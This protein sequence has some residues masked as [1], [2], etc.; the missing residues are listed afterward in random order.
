L[1]YT[2]NS[3]VAISR[4]PAEL[5][6]DV[7]LYVVDSGLW[8]D[9]TCF[10]AGTFNFLQVCRRWSEVAVAFPRL[11][12]WWVA[13]AGKAW[14][15]FNARSKDAPLFLTWKPRLP[16]SARDAFMDTGTPR[17]IY[18]L[19][20]SSSHAQLEYVLGALDSG[21]VSVT[22]SIRVVTDS[23]NSGEGLPRFLSLPFPKLLE[24]EI[25]NFLPDPSSSIFK[26]SNLTSL[27][28]S[29]REDDGRRYT[30]TQFSRI[31]QHHPNLRE[32]NL[33]GGAIPLAD[34]PG[35]PVSIV[36][37]W[38]VDLK[39]G[40]AGAA[41][42]GFM[43]LVS[44]SPLHNVAI[45]LQHTHTSTVPALSD[46][47]KQILT[48]YYECQGLEHPRKVDHLT[49]SLRDCLVVNAGSSA[50]TSCHPTYNFELLS[51]D[52]R[53]ALVGKIVPLF[54]SEHTR[55][56]AAAGLDLVTND[57]RTTLQNMKGLLHLRLDCL[58]IGPVL[59]ALDSDD[60][61]TWGELPES[62]FV[63]H[64]CTV[65]PYRPAAPKLQSL[66]LRN[67]NILINQNQKLFEVLERRFNDRIGLKSLTVQ[68]CSVPTS[69]HREGLDDL[70][71]EVTWDVE[72]MGQGY[73]A[74]ELGGPDNLSD[75]S[76]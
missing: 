33:R 61:G 32:L 21:S 70:V 66:S 64:T 69:E 53:K 46:A 39:L 22:S 8:I 16:D 5:L 55:I 23:G 72:E 65:K 9:D 43:D 75:R 14:H 6:S 44:M 56:F 51:F 13:S 76:R 1:R 71:E 68:S 28:L 29:V 35:E 4:L 48:A 58:D 41:I 57:W 31:L 67:L 73:G 24:L 54:P 38:L 36:L 7:F 37:P 45:Y 30:R 40:G 17:K 11:W 10:R 34:Q 18:Q 60:G 62:C 49:V 47:V 52:L 3:R 12:V 63:T 25:A 59:D 20:L 19:N 15:L 42:A 26:T 50:T 74:T 27:K 2:Q